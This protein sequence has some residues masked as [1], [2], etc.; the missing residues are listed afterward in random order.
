MHKRGTDSVISDLKKE[1]T[2]SRL[3][4]LEKVH[5]GGSIGS[6]LCIL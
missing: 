2:T 4:N 3:G 1:K 5:E 6:E